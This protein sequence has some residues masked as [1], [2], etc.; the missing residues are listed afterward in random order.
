[1]A[2]KVVCVTGASG[3][4]ASWLVKLLLRRGDP[5]KVEHLKALEGAKERLHLFEANL[6]EEGSFDR[7]IDGCDGVFHTASPVMLD[8]ANIND[9]QA[10]CV[11]RV[12][13][14]SSM[15]TIMANKFTQTTNALFD[16]TW[17]SDPLFAQ[18]NQLWYILSKI[19]AEEAATKFAKENGIDLVVINPGLVIGPLLQPTLNESSQCFLTLISQ[20]KWTNAMPGGIFVFVD[21]RDV[22]D[23]HILAFEEASANGRY[24]VV[25]K[26]LLC[27]HLLDFLRQLYPTHN[28][29][30]SP[31]ENGSS[32]TAIAPFQVCNEKAKSLGVNFISM[33]QSVQDTIQSLIDKNFFTLT[34]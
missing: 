2:G 18:E 19:L 33:E 30:I 27:S 11:K 22:C 12:V 29:P 3:Y 25:S 20:G 9:P 32:I 28:F 5:S 4:I 24:C 15:A 1:M 16:E 10:Q 17:F 21:V 13:L 6:V 23:A 8:N 14:T 7:V 31:E 26:V 34:M